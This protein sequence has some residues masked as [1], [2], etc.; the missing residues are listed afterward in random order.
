MHRVEF[1]EARFEDYEGIATL[2]H[3]QGLAS[4]PFDEWRRLWIGNPCF[5]EMRRR[6]PIGWVLTDGNRIAGCLSNIPLAYMFQGRKLIVAAGRGWAVEDQYRSYSPLLMDEYFQQENVDIFL[7]N[8]VNDKA[9]KAFDTFGSLRVPLGDW[10]SAAFVVTGHRGFAESALRIKEIPQPRLLSYV[11]GAAL[12]LKDRF[13]AK[14]IPSS[15]IEA[16]LTRSFDHR[17]DTFWN[18]LCERSRTLL[19]VRSRDVLQWRFGAGLKNGTIWVLTAGS[20]DKIDAYAIFQQRD[21][22]QYFL[23]RARIIDFQARDQ[24]DEYCAALT[25][26][27]CD[28]CCAQGIHVLEQ[29]G[30]NLIKSRVFEQAAPYRRKLPSWSFFYLAKNAELAG[31]LSRPEAWEPSSYDGDA[32]L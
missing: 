9:A 24:H 22:P 11:A 2:E 6:W 3:S 13:V 32:S 15:D 20:N 23:K 5:K 4:K 21:E 25:R 26:R 1:R 31:H 14:P 18:C 16:T 12:S 7:N 29:V 28:E 30:C 10:G 27:A 19:A 17:F 8:T